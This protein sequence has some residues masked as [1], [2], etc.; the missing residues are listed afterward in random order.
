[1][2]GIIAS[3]FEPKRGKLLF[4]FSFTVHSRSPDSITPCGTYPAAGK[5]T[6]YAKMHINLDQ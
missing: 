3:S 5:V 2:S 6:G 4:F 1:M